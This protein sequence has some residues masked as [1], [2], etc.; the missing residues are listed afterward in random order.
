MT[1]NL[2]IGTQWGDEGK[3]KVV[4]YYS[5]DAD[6]VVRFQGGSITGETPVFIKNCKLSNIVKIKDFIDPFFEKDEEG[7]KPIKNTSTFGANISDNPGI[8]CFDIS[9]TKGIYR[10]KADEIYKIK[11][12][13]GNISLTPDHSIFIYDKTLGKPICKKTSEVKKGDILVSF[14]HK[15]LLRG[16][17]KKNVYFSDISEKEDLKI[18]FKKDGFF[19]TLPISDEL[20][21]LFGYYV[22]EGN[23]SIRKRQ[24]KEKYRKSP[25]YDYDITFSFN[26]KEE[27]YIN[28]ILNAMNELFNENNPNIFSPP[29]EN[30]ETCIRYSK[31][32]LA[33]LFKDL[34]GENARNKKLPDFFFNFSREQFLI[35][36]KAYLQGDGYIHKSGKIEAST[37][38]KDL[39]IQLNWLSNLHGIKS[40]F[41]EKITKE[42]KSPQGHILQSIKV[43]T[44]KIGESSNPFLDREPKRKNSFKLRRIL[45][46]TKEPYSGF[47]Y[48]LCGCDNEAFFGGTSPILLHNSNA[49]HTIKVGDEVYKLHLTPSGVIQGK[50]GVIGNGVVVDPEI[51]MKEIN[52]LKKRGKKPK[53]LI[54]DRANIIM[55][56]HKILDGAEEKVLGSKK[57][58]T[59]GRGIGPCYSDKIARNGIR[60]IDLTNKDTLNKRLDLILPIKQRIFKAYEITEK[61]DKKTIL[62]K[63]LDYGNQLKQYITQTHITLNKAI[64]LGKNILLEGAQGTML[65]VDFG[66]YPFATSSHTIAGGSSIGSG[67]GPKNIDEIIGIVKA[68]TTRVGEGPMPTELFDETGKYLQEKGHEFG[69]TTSRPRRCGWLDL[70]VVKHSCMISGVTKLAITKIDVLNGLKKIKICTKYMLDGKEIDY[71]PANIEDVKKCKPIYKEFK[72][73]TQIN[74]KSKC[75][76]DLPIEAQKYLKYIEKETKTP[77]SLISIGPGRTETIDV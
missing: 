31:K 49:G 54:S 71:F 72:G 6:Y 33:Y 74:T 64:N 20:L 48:D 40:T 34:F 16:H 24:R 22:A 43:Y 8:K 7:F 47:V 58:G 41:L 35:F 3:G 29:N 55:P 66:T 51:L 25:S 77:L 53:L 13:G 15:N 76:S 46:I 68:Y 28:F 11:Y 4:D 52:E 14:P 17:N 18:E 38:S 12:N 23:S 2:V 21:R 39:A 75:F 69:T 42:R 63:Y 59:T 56:Y 65:D 57:I 62:E 19:Q 1:V 9:N 37:V 44:L 45:E 70:V 30:S 60:A 36:F 5:K 50:T 10:H 26:S 32:Y 73:W 27:D 67:I 61:L